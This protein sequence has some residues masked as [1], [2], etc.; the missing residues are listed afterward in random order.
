MLLK[1]LTTPVISEI[2]FIPICS[3]EGFNA[4]ISDSPISLK[5]LPLE[6]LPENILNW[7]QTNVQ[8]W[9]INHGLLRMARLFLVL[10]VVVC[11][12]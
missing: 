7:T 3:Q 9:L 6:T 5:P 11:Y 12:I 10:M 8:D 2:A 4:R 1:E